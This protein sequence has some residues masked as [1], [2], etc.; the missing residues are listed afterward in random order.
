MLRLSFICLLVVSVLLLS[1]V[2]GSDN[3]RPDPMQSRSDAVA[4]NIFEDSPSSTHLQ[5]SFKELNHEKIEIDGNSL[6][7]FSIDGELTLSIEGFPDLPYISRFLLIPPQSDVELR[8][9]HIST[10][11]EPEVDPVIASAGNEYTISLTD[12]EQ[13]ADYGGLFPFEPVKVSKPVIMRG[14][15][16]VS[17]TIFPMQYDRTTGQMHINEELDFE[18]IYDGVGENVITNP[19]RGRGSP[20]FNRIIRSLVENPPPER[21]EPDQRGSI[22]YVTGEWDDVLEELEPLI[23]WRRRMGWTAE[24]I[25]VGNSQDPYAVKREIQTAYDEWEIPPEYVV[26]VGDAPGDADRYLMGYFNEQHGS[27]YAYESDHHYG[28]L[29]GDDIFQDVAVGRLSFLTIG[30]LR[31]IVD[32]TVQY[33]S[34]PFIGEDNEI[35]W[36]KRG[37]VAA[38]YA[39]SGR[40]TIDVCAWS[41]N[42][43]VRHGYEEVA[44]AYYD[45]GDVTP[46]FFYD[47]FNS[48]ISIFLYRGWYRMNGFTMQN[49][50]NLRNDQML[51]FIILATCNTGDFGHNPWGAGH[52]YTEL[53][54][55]KPNGGAIGA[56]GAAGATHTAYNNIIVAGSMKALFADGIYTQGWTL[57]R[58]KIDLHRNYANLGDMMHPEN[59]EQESWLTSTY[60]FNLMGDP[61]VD[62]YTD[63]PRELNISHPEILV[64]GQSHLAVHVEYADTEEDATDIQVCLYKPDQ[65]QNVTRTDENGMAV[66]SLDPQRIQQGDVQLTVTGH[67]LM[68][69]LADMEIVDAEMYFGISHFDVSDNDDDVLNPANE[70]RLTLEVFNYGN[71]QPEGELDLI[72]AEDHPQLDVIEAEAHIESAPEPGESTEVDFRI[73]VGGGFLDGEEAVFHLSVTS[74]EVQWLSSFSIPVEA[75]DLQF[76]EFAWDQDPLEPEGTADLSITIE[77]VGSTDAPSLSARLTSL[78]NT[79]GVLI[80]VSRFGEI[81]TGESAESDGTFR[82]SANRFHVPGNSADFALTLTSEDGFVDTTWFSMVVGEAEESDP[83][84]PDGYGYICFDNHDE[85][86]IVAPIFDWIEIDPSEGGDGVDTELSDHDEEDD[87]SVLIDLPFT[88]QCYGEEFDQIT[89]CT[90]GWLAM[91][92]QANLFNGRNTRIPGGLVASG[93]ICPYWNDLVTLNDGGIFTYYSEEEH[94]FVIQW[95]RVRRLSPNGDNEHQLTFEAIL[96]DADFYPSFTGDGDILFQYLFIE[97][98]RQ[99]FY[100]DTPYCTVGIGSVDQTDGL[101]YSYWNR[102][103]P[104]AT[105]LADELAIKFTT[106]PVNFRGLTG[107]IAGTVTDAE[108]GAPIEGVSV[109]GRWTRWDVTDEN[110]E[111]LLEDVVADSSFPEELT[112]CKEF[113]TIQIIS[114]V[115]VIS[116]ETTI[117]N[118][119]MLHPEIAFEPDEAL[120]VCVFPDSSLETSVT[121]T[122]DG[123]SPLWFTTR[124]QLLMDE[125]DDADETWDPVFMWE[126]GE[127]VDDHRLEGIVFIEDNWIISGSNNGDV[128]TNYFYIFDRIGNHIENVLQPVESRY[129]I[130]GMTYHNGFI[131]GVE[132]THLYELNPDNFSV[133]HIFDL[134]VRLSSARSLAIDPVTNHFFISAISN[135]IWEFELTNDELQTV[136]TFEPFDPRDG[137]A[138]RRYGMAWFRDDPDGCP[139]YIINNKDIDGDCNVPDISIFKMNP[140]TSEIHYL[141]SLS[142]L[143]PGYRGRG[144]IYITPGWHNMIWTFA[145]VLDNPDG[146]AVGLFELAPNHS[147]L[148]YSPTADT[149]ES[150][151]SAEMHF[152][153]ETTNLDTGFYSVGIQFDHNAF[154]GWSLLPIYVSVGYYDVNQPEEPLPLE[155][156]LDQNYPNP[157]NSSTGI[158]YSLPNAGEVKLTIY[159]ILGREVAVPVNE[160][161][162]V[163]RYNVSFDARE[164]AAGIYFYRLEVGEYC[165]VRKMVLVK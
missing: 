77:N 14:Y 52:T 100:W 141:T 162:P 69:Y 8:L 38:G 57:V 114:S 3:S 25:S 161:Q 1:S 45:R 144:G 126:A 133:N 160:R 56:V 127:I 145:A 158:L 83:F 65:F 105:P 78:T 130:R 55:K 98:T 124:H 12:A 23:E 49:I 4:V 93:M 112:A 113:W 53:F 28:Q 155:Y 46:Q 159:D 95:S 5:I 19:E 85:E 148:T 81:R 68:P 128:E 43:M 89:I 88:F 139:L 51:P 71:N 80:P 118:F 39:Y 41:K 109:S 111:Y 48:G 30:E 117:V 84:G 94:I 62:L 129:G 64:T 2:Y 61:A 9:N 99:C 50:Q 75:P 97:N 59:N 24:V 101:E 154:P 42:L 63:T 40:S 18:L 143:N 6:D 17:V 163:G 125:R 137:D 123:N 165:S 73:G 104:A 120:S 152:R 44:E 132:T 34:D 26:I 29:E 37:A 110:G 72:L 13:Y 60:I 58:G 146:D 164:L 142:Y 36:Y 135:D 116:D 134:P 11:I 149:L 150:G 16:M 103:N 156:S 106:I 33:E 22:L 157:F 92:N 119:G 20:M 153:F 90:N 87:E 108:T 32:K 10:R 86:W 35:G 79:I 76:I 15:R 151:E 147:W 115:Q 21:D 96:Y 140:V 67:N 27:P 107:D 70:Y 82:I 7:R 136:S 47:S 31:T 74:G 121:I 138:I 102:Y 91:G 131:Y 54:V 66:F 122:N